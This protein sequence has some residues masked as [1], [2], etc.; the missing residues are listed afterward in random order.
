MTPER[1]RSLLA[2][3][4]LGRAALFAAPPAGKDG[5][6]D[7]AGHWRTIQGQ[8]VHITSDGAVDAGG[9]PALRKVLAEKAGLPDRTGAKKLDS[10][11]GVGNPSVVGPVGPATPK[12]GPAVSDAA[13]PVPPAAPT[14]PPVDPKAA[15]VIARHGREP[16]A[17]GTLS[18]SERVGRGGSCGYRTGQIVHRADGPWM[19][20]AT[21]PA[22]HISSD[23]IE[24]NDD[25]HTYKEGPGHYAGYSIHPVEPTAADLARKAEGEKAATAG[26]A[27]AAAGRAAAQKAE[28]EFK[29]TV[30][31]AESTV[32]PP[33]PVEW[34]PVA[35]QPGYFEGVHEGERVVKRV[36]SSYDDYRE[37]YSGSPAATRRWALAAAEKAGTDAADA[38][39]FLKDYGGCHGADYFRHI[40]TADPETAARLKARADERRAREA[41]EKDV[42]AA[43]DAAR[44]H[45]AGTAER[46]EAESRWSDAADAHY[47]R[48]GQGSG[49][50]H[51]RQQARIKELHD[52]QNA[53]R[54][55]LPAA[56]WDAALE[57]TAPRDGGRDKLFAA[58]AESGDPAA[59][60][61][62]TRVYAA[63]KARAAAAQEKA[64]DAA[65]GPIAA[66]LNKV[67]DAD[68]APYLIRHVKDH[69]DGEADPRAWEKALDVAIAGGKL[70]V[71]D[72]DSPAWREFV[73]GCK[74]DKARADR[75]NAVVRVTG[76]TFPV[77]DKIKAIPGSYFR[78]GSW[79]IPYKHRNMLPRKISCEEPD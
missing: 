6:L 7:P 47:R 56:V 69:F 48:F 50:Y 22:R 44:K 32:A 31:P 72:G 64:V 34:T 40:L 55:G 54:A 26:R 28:D 74:A 1:R 12:E 52:A 9:H 42:Y 41:S 33:G 73:A 77:K 70:D 57:A 17:G 21:Y 37:Y 49:A 65:I 68:T 24:D 79:H 53:A 8:P 23:W 62:L 67:Y 59:R 76:N 30:P 11:P 60:A 3:T 15:E 4:P 16:R 35:G 43:G 20:T 18:Y 71:K 14:P 13:V 46:A 10:A 38:E 39:K 25:W 27:A 63:A 36:Y 75:E 2:R 78:G 58:Y 5:D 61:E 19:V 66:H 29:A 51:P 45:P